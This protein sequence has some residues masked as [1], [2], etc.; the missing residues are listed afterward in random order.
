MEGDEDLAGAILRGIDRGLARL[1][2]TVG[3][4]REVE[5]KLQGSTRTLQSIFKALPSEPRESKVVSTY[6][7]T[8]DDRLWRRGFSLRLRKKKGRFE[9]TLKTQ[10]PNLHDR[11]EWTAM[12]DEAVVDIG[13]LPSGAPRSWECRAI[14][15]VCR[16]V[17]ITRIS[18]PSFSLIGRK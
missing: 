13:A 12:L 2:K 1:N 9:L 15:T 11:G 18:L 14:P 7:D 16:N 6:Y 8:A 17:C 3:L 10:G 4:D 5:L